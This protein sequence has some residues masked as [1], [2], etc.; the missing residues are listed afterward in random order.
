MNEKIFS[1][2]GFAAKSGSLICGANTCEVEIKKKKIHLILIAKDTSEN[3][4]K[5]V[6]GLAKKHGIPWKVWGDSGEISK[7]VGKG[8]VNVFA[9]KNKDL[10]NAIIEN[11]DLIDKQKLGGDFGYESK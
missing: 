2:L 5:K 8:T 11:I 7:A 9:V 6:T 4:V 3:T 1:Y 10:A